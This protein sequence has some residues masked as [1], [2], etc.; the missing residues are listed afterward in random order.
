VGLLANSDSRFV[1]ASGMDSLKYGRGSDPGFNASYYLSIVTFHYSVYPKL[2]KAPTEALRLIIP[3]KTLKSFHKTIG[4]QAHQPSRQLFGIVAVNM[5][6][7]NSS[8]SLVEGSGRLNVP[9]KNIT[10]ITAFVVFGVLTVHYIRV[11][12]L[13]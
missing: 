11:S 3:T 1:Q 13:L 6:Q 12:N 10:Y 5:L 9:N 7:N 8:T 4:T 2:P